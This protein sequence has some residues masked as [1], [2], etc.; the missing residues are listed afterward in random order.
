MLLMGHDSKKASTSEAQDGQAAQDKP[1][2]EQE[3]SEYDVRT[4]NHCSVTP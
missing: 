3:K 2:A 4:I 1:H